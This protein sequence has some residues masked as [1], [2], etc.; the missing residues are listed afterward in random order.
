MHPIGSV[1]QRHRFYIAILHV[2]A[3]FPP[4]SQPREPRETVA[5][6]P[7]GTVRPHVT[8]RGIDRAPP[9]VSATSTVFEFATGSA[10]KQAL[11]QSMLLHLLVWNPSR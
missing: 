10:T 5:P 4:A 11:N 2:P 9:G 1:Q 8:S 6:P 7:F 3:H